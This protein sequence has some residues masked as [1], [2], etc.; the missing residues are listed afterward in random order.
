[1]RFGRKKLSDSDYFSQEVSLNEL[2]G[3]QESDTA[4]LSSVSSATSSK[5]LLAANPLRLGF[6]IYNDSDKILYVAFASTA[7]A[8]AFTYRVVPAATL[9]VTKGLRYLGKITG[10][11]ATGVTG[12]ARI[13]EFS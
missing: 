6:I 5:T 9:E 12:S 1:M 2:L 13:T 3:L 4:S 8:T 7:S 10:I 11:W